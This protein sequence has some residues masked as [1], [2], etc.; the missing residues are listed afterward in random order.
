[1]TIAWVIAE[2][3]VRKRSALE[4]E[5]DMSKAFFKTVGDHCQQVYRNR[6]D[7]YLILE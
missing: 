3:L 4:S 5:S 2:S 6:A 1:M 7:A